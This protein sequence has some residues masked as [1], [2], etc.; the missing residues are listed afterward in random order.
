M[1]KMELNEKIREIS[2]EIGNAQEKLSQLAQENMELKN[3]INELQSSQQNTYALLTQVVNS[4]PW[5]YYS[6]VKKL[7][8][9]ERELEVTIRDLLNRGLLSFKYSKVGNKFIN[10]IKNN[11][12]NFWGKLKEC[13]IPILTGHNTTINNSGT[14]I[15]DNYEKNVSVDG[16]VELIKVFSQQK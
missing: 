13:V 8:L 5:R 16:M 14:G 4:K 12:P 10:H 11:Y 2:E 1:D 6:R 7:I 15:V 9:P 3:K